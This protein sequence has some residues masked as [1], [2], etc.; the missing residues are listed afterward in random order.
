MTLNLNELYLLTR[1][2]TTGMLVL[3]V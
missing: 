3:M 2:L 1:N